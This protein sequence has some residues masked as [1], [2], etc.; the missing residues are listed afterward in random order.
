MGQEIS[1]IDIELAQP[2][3]SRVEEAQA[4]ATALFSRTALCTFSL[5]AGKNSPLSAFEKNPNVK[6]TYASSTLKV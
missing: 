3:F 2:V 5:S 1:T 4:H 6:A